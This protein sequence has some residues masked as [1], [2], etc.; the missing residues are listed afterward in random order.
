MAVQQ[1]VV[2][3]GAIL[4]WP[5]TTPNPVLKV[6]PHALTLDISGY[7]WLSNLVI[8]SCK[9]INSPLYCTTTVLSRPIYSQPQRKLIW[10]T[11]KPCCESVTVTKPAPMTTA[12]YSVLSC[13]VSP[14]EVLTARRLSKDEDLPTFDVFCTRPRTH[15]SMP[16]VLTARPVLTPWPANMLS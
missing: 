9:P 6:T 15:G 12:S 16:V 8:S 1:K 10:S 5:W 11:L 7:V 13:P 2:S 14:V 4:Q 3:N